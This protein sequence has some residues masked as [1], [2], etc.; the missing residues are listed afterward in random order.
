MTKKTPKVYQQLARQWVKPVE[1]EPEPEPEPEPV[2]M[3]DTAADRRNW[4]RKQAGW[5]LLRDGLRKGRG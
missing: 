4:L 5:P 1:L 3:E 2:V